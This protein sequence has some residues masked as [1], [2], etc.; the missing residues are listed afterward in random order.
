MV[1]TVINR[2]GLAFTMSWCRQW[3]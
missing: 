2:A 1:T 3:P